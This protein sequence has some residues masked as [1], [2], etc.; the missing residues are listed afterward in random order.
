METE[1]FLNFRDC[2][3]EYQ[4]I[5]KIL[6]DCGF[7]RLG[8]GFSLDTGECVIYIASEKTTDFLNVASYFGALMF[9]EKYSGA[10]RRQYYILSQLFL[11]H[12]GL[13]D[14]KIYS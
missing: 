10:L 9:Q 11:E 14:A 5:E 1:K 4:A 12:K 2:K 8:F 3:F 6:R 7:K 13:W